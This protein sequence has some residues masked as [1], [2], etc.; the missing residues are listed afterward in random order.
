MSG[1]IRQLAARL[2]GRVAQPEP[3]GPAQ[4]Q[5]AQMAFEDKRFNIDVKVVFTTDDGTVVG[6]RHGELLDLSYESFVAAQGVLGQVDV[7]LQKMGEAR[8]AARAAEK[9][10]GKR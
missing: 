10:K 5:E 7:Q 8:V 4:Q 9:A 2:G 1:A 6:R 3:V